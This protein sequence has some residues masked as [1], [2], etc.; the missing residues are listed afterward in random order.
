[1]LPR[2]MNLLS[3]IAI[4]CHLLC[5]STGLPGACATWAEELKAVSP[6]EVGLSAEKLASIDKRITEQIE[7]GKIAGCQALIF[8]DGQIGYFK[9]WGQRDRERDL[10]MQQDTIF[11][12]YSMTKPITSVAV[13]QLFEQG[14]LDLDDPVSEFLPE[15]KDLQVQDDG[16]RLRP[17]VR[18]MTIR[19]LLRHTSGMTYG[20]F[21][22]TEV[23]KQYRKAGILVT[24]ETIAETVERLATL[25]LMR[26][27]G[28]RFHYSVSTDVLGRVVE[29][30]SGERFDRY[31]E[32]HILQPLGMQ[33]TSFS[34]PENH[35]PR[36]AQ[37]YVPRSGGLRP[38]PAVSSRR[39]VDQ[40]NLYFSGGGGLCSTMAD[41]LKFARMLLNQGELDGQRII[42]QETWQEMTRDQLADLPNQRGRF[43]FGLGV[44]IGRRG[45][46]GWGGAAGTRFWVY[47][48]EN[49]IVLFMIQ[50][51]PNR[52]DFS[53]MVKSAAE[54]SVIND[55]R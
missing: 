6:E 1:M 36:L 7:A 8:K 30:V 21:G 39:F 44:S 43:Q 46:F 32:K 2:K 25:P 47:P 14:K 33:D 40:D 12:I 53:Q 28:E 16:D 50:N 31:L 49:M 15:L 5:W 27:P 20:F 24:Q 11:R 9:L 37:L 41:Y 29:V 48:K 4:A 54:R 35:L 13:L 17:A 55:Q 38:A 26:D 18:E 23:D 3:R 42:K 22:D 19:D 52:P 45:E 10:Q 51:N 34:V